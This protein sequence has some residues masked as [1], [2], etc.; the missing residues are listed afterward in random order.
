MQNIRGSDEFMDLGFDVK[1]DAHERPPSAGRC[2]LQ[3]EGGA[4]EALDRSA[5]V[6]VFRD[7][8]AERVLG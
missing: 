7:Q 5:A 3:P 1:S 4:E 6:A 2:A 8:K